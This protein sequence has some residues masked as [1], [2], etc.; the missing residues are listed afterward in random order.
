M[1][2]K[3]KIKDKPAFKSSNKKS[4]INVNRKSRIISGIANTYFFID[5]DGDMLI[6]GAALK[7]IN[8]NGVNSQANYKIPH[9]AD[10]NYNTD[11]IIGK[12]TV[13]DERIIDGKN[14]LYFESKMSKTQKGN[15]YLIKYEEGIINQHSI[16]MYYVDYMPASRDSEDESKR[17]AWN[18][19]YP[20]VLNK[21][22][23]DE[24]GFF[25]IVKEI[26]LIEISAV[27]RGNNDET[28]YLGLKS[29]TDRREFLNNE[30]N[31]LYKVLNNNKAN[32]QELQN[33][34]LKLH[35]IQN[36]TKKM[37]FITQK[38]NFIQ[39]V[40]KTTEK[41]QVPKEISFFEQLNKYLQ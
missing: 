31:E 10:H 26:R 19:Y 23:A 34:I 4:T 25:W 35:K 32:K 40:K 29:E 14:V 18:N 20:V 11:N 9:L 24:Y 17:I 22:R 33:A 13:L 37:N 6:P 28:I 15:D 27:I 2:Y 21:E 36:F 12:L 39:P 1:K 30:F 3:E 7:T 8:E 5:N 16:A 38:D 41:K